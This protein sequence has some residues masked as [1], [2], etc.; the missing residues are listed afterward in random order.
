MSVLVMVAGVGDL[1]LGESA[2]TL[3]REVEVVLGEFHGRSLSLRW[4]P[5]CDPPP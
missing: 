4:I 2:L 3:D 1:Y 5:N